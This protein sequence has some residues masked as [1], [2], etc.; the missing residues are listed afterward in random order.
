MFYCRR[1]QTN[2]KGLKQLCHLTFNILQKLTFQHLGILSFHFMFLRILE[3]VRGFKMKH[4]VGH[5]LIKVFGFHKDI[6]NCKQSALSGQLFLRRSYRS[7][8]PT[9]TNSLETKKK[10]VEVGFINLLFLQAS[11]TWG[12]TKCVYL[13]L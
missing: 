4:C 11:E 7:A 10:T 9:W 1:K 8:F 5:W 2:K 12:E 13:S 6:C 3:L